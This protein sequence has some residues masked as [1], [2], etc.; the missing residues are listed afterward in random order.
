MLDQ[1][2]CFFS[3]PSG[4]DSQLCVLSPEFIC[5][6]HRESYGRRNSFTVDEAERRISSPED[7]AATAEW[8]LT[9]LKEMVYQLQAKID[10]LENRGRR[11]NLKIVGLP[12][13]SEGSGSL[14]AFLRDM[15]P[16]W[17]DLPVDF[18]ALDI[19]RAHRSPT[20]ASNNP[21]A[22]PRSIL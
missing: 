15:I 22:A 12:E 2:C 6:P 5:C 1:Q 14:S 21:N 8:Q 20:F 17:L 7:S 16:K 9:R 3:R 19:E 4:G 18:P 10:D 13:K 11:K